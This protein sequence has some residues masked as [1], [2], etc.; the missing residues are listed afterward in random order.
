MK[1]VVLYLHAHQPW[2][3]KP[4]SIFQ[5]GHDHLYFNDETDSVNT[6]NQFIIDKVSEKSYL[7]TNE[8]LKR[9]LQQHPEF[10]LSLSI[11]GTLIEQLKQWRPDV[12]NS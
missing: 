3:V 8:V 10:R 11:T 6:N 9:L 7:P 12:L 5:A 4:Y 1:S 2:R